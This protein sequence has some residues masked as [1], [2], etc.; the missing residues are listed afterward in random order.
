M[1]PNGCHN[2]K[3]KG[4]R[5]KCPTDR[6]SSTIASGV[7]EGPL[8]H[9][10]CASE[11]FFR[12]ASSHCFTFCAIELAKRRSALFR[13]ANLLASPVL[14]FPTTPLAQLQLRGAGT[15]GEDLQRCD[16]LRAKP[17]C[18]QRTGEHAILQSMNRHPRLHQ[19]I[20]HKAE[21]HLLS[22]QSTEGN[23]EFSP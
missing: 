22:R 15:V 9:H 12:P 11:Y 14:R 8:Q 18:T 20:P 7:S 1:L 6:L 13:S 19:E 5:Y 4:V 2:P 21:K 17:S 3:K 16:H 10:H 23:K